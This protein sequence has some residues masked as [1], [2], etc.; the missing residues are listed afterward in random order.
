MHSWYIQVLPARTAHESQAYTDELAEVVGVCTV[1]GAIRTAYLVDSKIDLS[2]D[3][4]STEA[5]PM[6]ATLSAVARGRKRQS[7]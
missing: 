4:K 6:P 7:T 1:C 2:G 5:T 3:C